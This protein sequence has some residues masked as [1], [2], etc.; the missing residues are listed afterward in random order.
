[1]TTKIEYYKINKQGG[2]DMQEHI[3]VTHE[4]LIKTTRIYTLRQFKNC[5]KDFETINTFNKTGT[6]KHIVVEGYVRVYG[7][8]IEGEGLN[9]GF[10]DVF[11]RR[12]YS[13]KDI[14]NATIVEHESTY[15]H[16][17]TIV[18]RMLK[19]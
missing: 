5:E 4:M 10:Y 16:N 2:N 12:L 13:K 14:E 7:Y 8:K 19:R 18:S 15:L 3:Y 1:M 6:G 11:N 9:C 17:D